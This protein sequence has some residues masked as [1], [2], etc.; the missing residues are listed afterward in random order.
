M[1][2]SWIDTNNQAQEV[3]ARQ[4]LLKKRGGMT[5]SSEGATAAAGW[6]GSD[7]A[8]DFLLSLAK[9]EDCE[10]STVL[11]KKMEKSWIQQMN[12]RRFKKSLPV[13]ISVQS[14]NQLKELAKYCG[15]TKVKT[16]ETII[17]NEV[18]FHKQEIA[19]QK[20][21]HERRKQKLE[22]CEVALH[23]VEADNRQ[24]KIELKE[25]KELGVEK[26]SSSVRRV[27]IKRNRGIES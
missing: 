7:S 27:S 12:K 10:A 25:L 11:L 13:N 9:K 23:A 1:K 21:D 20:D 2:R 17:A 4:Y 8:L 24:L 5:Q 16:L 15:M 3:W 19:K 26:K 6:A 18:S 22:Q 14:S